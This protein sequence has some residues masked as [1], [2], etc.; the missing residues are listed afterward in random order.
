[1]AAC[2]IIVTEAGGNFTDLD[3]R[4]GP[5]GTGGYAT[6]G[7]LHSAVLAQLALK[8]DD[9]PDDHHDDRGI[10]DSSTR[11]TRKRAYPLAALSAFC[12]PPE[13]GVAPA[14]RRRCGSMPMARPGWFARS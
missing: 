5:L 2:S 7:L 1:M 6:N 12:W 10:G 11:L 4:P 3:G 13:P 9:G 14:D 8:N